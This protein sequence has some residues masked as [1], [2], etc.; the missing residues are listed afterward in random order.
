MK[1][2]R[3]FCGLFFLW[4]L[5]LCGCGKVNE[6]TPY[7]PLAELQDYYGAEMEEEIVPLTTFTLPYHSGETW[8]PL[9]CGDGVQFTLSALVY[10]TMYVLD[11]T[12]TPHP[13]LVGMNERLN[14]EDSKRKLRTHKIRSALPFCLQQDLETI[15]LFSY[16]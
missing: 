2:Q 1:C 16:S 3:L 7:D 15:I 6:D 13:Q 8:D 4:L 9:T 10:E 5:L 11:E 12:F 14:L